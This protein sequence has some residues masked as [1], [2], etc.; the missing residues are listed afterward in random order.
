MRKK[1]RERIKDVSP[2]YS[3]FSFCSGSQGRGSVCLGKG[4]GFFFCSNTKPRG[5]YFFRNK[6]WENVVMPPLFYG[7]SKNTALEIKKGHLGAEI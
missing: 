1:E 4:G 3:F 7:Q 6:N 2:R 5:K